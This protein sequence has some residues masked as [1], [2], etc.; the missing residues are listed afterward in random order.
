MPLI[1]SDNNQVSQEDIV[2]DVDIDDRVFMPQSRI[3][4]LSERA[5]HFDEEKFKVSRMTL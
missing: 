4:A 2:Q 1:K 3:K 5:Q